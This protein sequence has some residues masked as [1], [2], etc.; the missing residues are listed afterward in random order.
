[1][2]HEELR[3]SGESRGRTTENAT[4]GRQPSTLH[5][6]KVAVNRSRTH[7]PVRDAR[8]DRLIRAHVMN[9]YLQ[10]KL[11]S[12][13]PRYTSPAVAKLSDHLTQFRLSSRGKKKGSRRGSKEVISDERTLMSMSATTKTR[14]IM[15]KDPRSFADVVS[16]RSLA[17]RILYNFPSPINISTPGMPALVEYYYRSFW[18]NSLACNPEGMWMSVAVSDPAMFH[19]TLCVVALHK[20]QTRGGPQASSYFWHRG[21][22]IRLISQNLADPEQAT[23]DATIG[24][25]AL[26]SAADNSV[27]ISI[28][29]D[30]GR[31]IWGL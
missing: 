28:L 11:L 29:I 6:V 30:K 21:E 17:N 3:I 22:A 7:F 12:S 23:S 25:V 13:K 1:M 4:K 20:F 27:S 16:A 18:D 14:T 31:E 19:A 9:N 8:D 26:L 2:A 10:Q 15:P 5:F 24:A